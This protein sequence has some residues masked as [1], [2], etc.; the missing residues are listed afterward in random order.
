MAYVTAD[1]VLLPVF[2]IF[3]LEDVSFSLE[4]LHVFDSLPK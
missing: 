2:V 3:R 1:K 4:T